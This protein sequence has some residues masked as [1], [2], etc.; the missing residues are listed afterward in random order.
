MTMRKDMLVFILVLLIMSPS[1]FPCAAKALATKMYA[2]VAARDSLTCPEILK[3]HFSTSL[4][5][6][7]FF[8]RYKAH[9]VNYPL[10]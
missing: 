8:P 1:S 6:V 7:N 3:F 4:Q 9:K 10:I 2:L 5:K